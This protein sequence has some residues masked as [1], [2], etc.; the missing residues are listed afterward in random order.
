[1]GAVLVVALVVLVV[2]GCAASHGGAAMRDRR[3]YTGCEGAVGMRI[4]CATPLCEG[5]GFLPMAVK[6]PGSSLWL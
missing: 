4:D 3:K 2:R 1:M 6:A 5:T